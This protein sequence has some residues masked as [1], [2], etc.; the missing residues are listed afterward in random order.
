MDGE[1]VRVSLNGFF[2]GW[3]TFVQGITRRDKLPDWECLWSDFT[4]ED[5]WIS[6]V[7][8]SSNRYKGSRGE[9]E[10]ENLAL[11]G[12]G[13]KGKTKSE[14]NQKSDKKKKNLNKIKCFHCHEFGHYASKCLN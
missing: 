1:L 8:D 6:I 7:E 9:K 3:A 2:K 4:Q 12:K 13:N 14:S 11:V 5:F 10:K